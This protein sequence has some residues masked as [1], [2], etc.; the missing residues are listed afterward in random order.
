MTVDRTG[1]GATYRHCEIGDF[2]SGALIALMAMVGIFLVELL[3]GN[4]RGCIWQGSIS[5]LAFPSKIYD[6][7]TRAEKETRLQTGIV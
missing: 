7:P 2:G 3:T 4:K 6:N 1:N 5:S